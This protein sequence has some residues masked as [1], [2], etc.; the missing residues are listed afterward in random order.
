MRSRLEPLAFGGAVKATIPGVRL[1][2]R[3]D[4][5]DGP[6]PEGHARVL[7]TADGAQDPAQRL[8][9]RP[10]PELPHVDSSGCRFHFTGESARER[11]AIPRRRRR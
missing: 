5:C 4:V 9:P 1:S 2:S 6:S 7:S 10:D 3:N 11:P 8:L